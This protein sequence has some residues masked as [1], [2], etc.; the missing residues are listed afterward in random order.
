MLEGTCHCGSVRL[1]LVRPPDYIN[2]CNCSLCRKLGACWGYCEAAAVTIGGSTATYLRHDV[3]EPTVGAHFCT[4]C[5]ATTHWKLTPFAAAKFAVDRMGINMR[6]FTPEALAGI[7][8]RFPDGAAW[9]GQGE[10]RF[11]RPSERVG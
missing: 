9:T 4:T 7:E 3:V 11:V 1:T 2:E 10:R 5:G 8:L 6:L